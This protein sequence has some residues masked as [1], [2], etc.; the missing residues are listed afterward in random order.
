MLEDAAS[1][2]TSDDGGAPLDGESLVSRAFTLTVREGTSDIDSLEV[3]IDEKLSPDGTLVLDLSGG[4]DQTGYYT[5]RMTFLPDMLQ[6][7]DTQTVTGT[8]ENVTATSYTIT[9]T[10][11]ETTTTTISWKLSSIRT[12]KEA[13]G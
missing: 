10:V 6:V 8:P 7:T 5:I 3:T 2:L 12:L 11:T 9:T 13:A 1:R 4:D